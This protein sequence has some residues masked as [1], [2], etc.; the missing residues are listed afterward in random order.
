MLGKK[1]YVVVVAAALPAISCFQS[2]AAKPLSPVFGTLV[3][4][5]LSFYSSVC[6]VPYLW[7]WSVSF[8]FTLVCSAIAS[9]TSLCREFMRWLVSAQLLV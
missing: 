6:P 1:D 9:L 8:E 4:N 7:L 5:V 3:H 2:P